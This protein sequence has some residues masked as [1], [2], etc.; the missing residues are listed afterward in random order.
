MDAGEVHAPEAYNMIYGTKKISHVQFLGSILGSV[1][2]TPDENIA[3]L[4][5]SEEKLGQF[6]IDPEDTLAFVNHLLILENIKIACMFRQQ[7]DFV[8]VSLRSVGQ[9]DVGIMAQA[10]G[11]GGH[12]HS[13]AMRIKGTLKDVEKN[14]INKLKAMLF[15]L[16]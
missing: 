3:W 15:D 4:S 13:A 10:L 6:Q 7:G 2:T 5:V 8:R 11:G 16:T 9:I 14:V 12:N 1:Q